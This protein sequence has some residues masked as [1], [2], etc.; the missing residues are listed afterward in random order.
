LAEALKR[1]PPKHALAAE[2]RQMLYEELQAALQEVP[3][4]DSRA[5]SIR[6]ILE[7]SAKP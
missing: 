2:I 6:E 4:D 3:P 7:K 5:A 1:V